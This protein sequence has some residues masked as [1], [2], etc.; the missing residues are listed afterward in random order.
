MKGIVF[1]EFLEMVEEVFSLEIA[2]QMLTDVEAELASG[3]AYTSVGIY[4]HAELVTLV[5]RL[6]EIV[7]IPVP[8]LVQA[9]GKH[10]FGR[11]NDLYPIFFENVSCTF[12]FLDSIENHIHIE[13]RK[14][15]PNAELPTF[16]T[17]IKTDSRMTMIY[18]SSRSF[19]DLAAGLID[20]AIHHFNENIEVSRASLGAELG[21]VE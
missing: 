16:E 6:S 5:V 8:D 17:T 20:G 12:D 13:V 3:G 14:L 1:S 15:Y 19:A 18:R 9:Y 2:D 11:F 10:L 7:D 4:D 21:T